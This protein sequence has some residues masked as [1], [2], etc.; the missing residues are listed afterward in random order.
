LIQDFSDHKITQGISGWLRQE[1]RELNVLDEVTHL[2]F[3]QSLL[4]GVFGPLRNPL[5]R[6]YYLWL[7]D[8]RDNL[9][10]HPS[11]QY[12]A[13]ESRL[14]P[15]E[16]DGTWD[17]NIASVYRESMKKDVQS[18]YSLKR[19]NVGDADAPTV[20][21]AKLVKTMN[22]SAS[23][24]SLLGLV[25]DHQNH[26]CAYDSLFT[27]LYNVW[28]INSRVWTRRLADLSEYSELLSQQFRSVGSGVRFEEARDLVREKLRLAAST[29]FPLGA[30][31]TCLNTL[32]LKM[33]MKRQRQASGYC[34]LVC[35]SCQSEGRN[36]LNFGEFIQ[37][38]STGPFQDNTYN[39]SFIS[40]CLGWH[41]SE[42][43][44]IS[45]KLCT[46]CLSRTPVRRSFMR[47]DIRVFRLPYIMCIALNSPRFRINR[48]L[49][50]VND[51]VDVEYRLKGIIYGDGAHFVSR[52]VDDEERVWY[53]D[54]MTT[55]SGCLLEGSLH[56]SPDDE[57]LRTS[58]RGH[59]ERRAILVIYI[60]D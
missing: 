28:N 57:W 13:H 40:D 7:E 20:D 41:L 2:R 24:S 46:N 35:S 29:D 51:G 49:S 26:S 11:I 50:Y 58:F 30:T 55:G 43:Q 23:S 17:I 5:I 25:W 3:E 53:H 47:L 39:E 36:I 48:R 56:M 32:T 52:I 8:K 4:E 18:H 14:K 60:R 10:W 45:K 38:C 34:R 6:S 33:M 59:S 42:S 1:F 27:I 15:V 44:K 9:D 22:S 21:P 16:A 12:E 19:S 37:L 54:G 31:P